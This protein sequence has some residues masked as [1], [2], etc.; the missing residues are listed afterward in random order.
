MPDRKSKA[1]LAQFKEHCAADTDF[2]QVYDFQVE[3][4][5]FATATVRLP[6]D[7][8]HL[9]PGPTVGGPAMMAIGDYAIWA[10]VVGAY[11]VMAKMAVTTSLNANF[12]RAAGLKDLVCEARV[13]KTGK[14]LAVG[15]GSVYAA[16]VEGPVA[17]V[18]ATYSIP[19]E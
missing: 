14:R 15:E 9:R 18:T 16:G 12:L 11:G 4:I 7:P 17:H 13:I 1:T 19:P 8:K 10:A 6:Y 3:K 5:E 2:L